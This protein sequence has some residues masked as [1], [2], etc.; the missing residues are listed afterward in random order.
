MSLLNY[1]ITDAEILSIGIDHESGGA[2]GGGEPREHHFTDADLVDFARALLDRV[3]GAQTGVDQPETLVNAGFEGG[4]DRLNS[5]PSGRVLP[6]A[7]ERAIITYGT[8]CLRGADF[9]AARRFL[10]ERIAEVIAPADTTVVPVLAT[11]AMLRPF[12]NC[13]A[14]ELPMAWAACLQI[15][16]GQRRRAVD[17]VMDALQTGQEQQDEPDEF[18]WA[19]GRKP[20]AAPAT[21]EMALHAVRNEAWVLQMNQS[22]PLLSI[23]E[24]VTGNGFDVFRALDDNQQDAILRQCAALAHDINQTLCRMQEAQP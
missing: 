10:V 2:A 12:L 3:A 22:L 13:P 9:H 20:A 4:P 23:L 18:R 8:A 11:D 5:E 1:D 19:A 21:A 6:H 15:A 14:D 7:V 17:P 16:G 24:M